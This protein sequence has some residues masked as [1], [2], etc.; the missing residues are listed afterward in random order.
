MRSGWRRLALLCLA[1]GTAIAIMVPWGSAGNRVGETFFDALPGPARVSYGKSI[2]YRSTLTN[3]GKSTFTHVI[4]RMSVPFV[5]A[6][7]LQPYVEAAFVASNCPSTPVVVTTANGREWTC[8]FGKLTP[9]T[10]GTPQLVLTTVW[11]APTLAQPEGCNGC[12]QTNGRWTIKEGVNDVADPND[13][14]PR[15]GTPV[16]A[17]LLSPNSTTEAGAYQTNFDPCSN[18]FGQGSLT[19]SQNLDPQSNPNSTTACLPSPIPTNSIDFGLATKIVE[20]PLQS[21]DPG[22]S[23][24]GR[25]T[26]CIAALGQTCEE[27]Y[28]PAN[29]SP[30][31]TT[32]VLRG[33]ADA[34]PKNA[35]V[36]A[37]YHNNHLLPSCPSA[38]PNGCVVSITL[39]SGSFT[40]TAL[41]TTLG[42]GGDHDDHHDD[43]H[44]DGK[45]GTWTAVVKASTNGWYTW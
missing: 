12:L 27:G 25:S 7:G 5:A 32:I 18:A 40:T 20:G 9:G 42:R 34:L 17:T 44:G 37:V 8:D 24:F 23:A 38:D 30:N 13:T 10:P 29:F 3:T 31:V 14:L 21:G 39:D 33:S 36:T 41:S 15:G 19:T 11:T 2:A 35:K 16:A 28:V 22:H 6:A 1:A 45:G 4:F 26:V 43:H